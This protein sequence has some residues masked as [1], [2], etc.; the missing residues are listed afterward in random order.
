M[1]E[2]EHNREY[3]ERTICFIDEIHRFNKAQQ[4]A[5]LP[6]VE[7][8]SI[9]LIG[10][11]TENPSFEINAALLSRC[12]VLVLKALT[13]EN[14]TKILQQALTNPNGF[15]D[16]QVQ[17]SPATLAMIAEFA[18]GDA[19]I[20]LNTLEMAVLNGHRQDQQVSIT[21]NDLQQLIN[22]KSLRYDKHGE[23]HYNIISALHK[24]MRNSD[25]DA[26]VYWCSRMLDG[27]EDPLYIARRLVR[28]A[29]EDI[30]L[31]DTNALR[32]A[33]N[34]FQACQ[35]LGMPEC[36]VHLTECVIYLALAP[37]SNAAYQARQRAKRMIK[38]TGNLPVPLQI[39]NAPTKLMKNLH[40]GKD[41][42]YAHD[43]KDKLTTMQTMPDQLVGEHFY[44]PTD[45]GLEPRFQARMDQIKAWHQQHDQEK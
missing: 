22:T 3:G 37:K 35:F 31:A 13:K 26:A 36:D 2:A 24:S 18:N 8:G 44:Q 17:A 10:A 1:E 7:K 41:Y 15:P 5:F 12:K 9:I 30:G 23:E 45:Q 19:R 43:S 38:K 34:T 33:I 20:A 21:E 39:R 16:L 14:I 4:D 25:V 6:F 40:Y 28:F 27:G 32:V 42:Q 11:T 29:S